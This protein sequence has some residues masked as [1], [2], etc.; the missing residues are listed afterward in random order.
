MKFIV[1]AYDLNEKERGGPILEEFILPILGKPIARL[2]NVVNEHS[3]FNF[4]WMVK[5]FANAEVFND[6]TNLCSLI[7]RK[8]PKGGRDSFQIWLRPLVRNLCRCDVKILT[9]R[10]QVSEDWLAFFD[11]HYWMVVEIAQLLVVFS[12]S[13]LFLFAFY[14]VTLAYWHHSLATID[15]SLLVTFLLE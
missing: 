9:L 5:A 15:L 10:L 2:S 14:L 6:L 8:L 13:L 12:L 3:P 7:R 11:F 1:L 4:P